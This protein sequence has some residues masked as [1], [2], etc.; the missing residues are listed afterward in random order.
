MSTLTNNSFVNIFKAN[1]GIIVVLILLFVALSI[2]SPVFL[3][4]NNLITLFQQITINTFLA[5]GMT[6]VIIL[7]GIDLSVGAIVAMSGTVTVGLMVNSGLPI[8]LAIV[9]GLALGTLLGLINGAVITQFGLPPFIVTLATMYVGQGIAYIYSG[10]RSLRVTD[11]AFTKLGTTRILDLI[12]IPI[13]YMAVFIIIFSVILMKT[14]FGASIYAMGGNREAARLSGIPIKRIEIT[15]YTLTGFMSAFA[16]IVLAARMYSGQPSVGQ[17]YE[18]DAIAACVL[19][20]VS[21]AGG[22]GRI[23]GTV[24]GA[25]VIGVVSN[26]L[27]LMGVISFWQLLVM[28]LIILVAVI[29]DSQKGKKLPFNLAFLKRANHDQSV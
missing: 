9:I 6:Y 24:F 10:G 21:M 12:P 13:I 4:T 19:G 18:L 22:K 11:E 16:G 20:G 23:S 8:V 27:N 2:M 25:I 29:I 1:K 7:G 28:G 14:R 17:G 26:G 3:T 5:L 15:V